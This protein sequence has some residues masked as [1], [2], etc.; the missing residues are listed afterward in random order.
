MRQLR[1]VQL[2]EDGTHLVLKSGDGVEDF[3]VALDQSLRDAVAGSS[4]AR[5]P[6][7]AAPASAQPQESGAETAP[8]SPREIQ[9]RVRSGES[10]EQVAQT[11]GAPLERIMRFAAAVVDERRRITEEAR[12]SRARQTALDAADGKIV[13]FGDAVNARFAAHGISPAEVRWDSH[14]REDGEWIVV[15]R[16]VGGAGAGEAHWVFSR[17]A[18]MV[19]P[20]DDTA[21]DLL[22]NRPIRPV[23]APVPPRLVVAPPL[24]PG[25]VAFPPMPEAH[26]GPIA[27]V[28]EV[29]DQEAPPDQPAAPRPVRPSFR[30]RA[31]RTEAQ[32]QPVVDTPVESP[33]EHAIEQPADPATDEVAIDFDAPLLPFGSG[34]AAETRP[35]A[36]AD[37]QTD[38]PTDNRTTAKRQRA[39]PGRAARPRVPSW[40]DIVLGVR[41]NND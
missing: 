19:T 17:A 8:I 40:D 9:M 37:K 16:W 11:L 10:P 1:F 20:A 21:A 38:K 2:T 41:R 28:E 26:T 35:A 13:P 39:E 4:A 23:A 30:R 24:A 34:E 32:P 12:R 14:R 25:V 6:D 27:V 22:N 18:R 15:A 7:D 3:G 31:E 33:V 29:F 5:P 36:L